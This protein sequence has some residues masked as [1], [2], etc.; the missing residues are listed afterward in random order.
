MKD[1]DPTYQAV[2]KAVR[3]RWRRRLLAMAHVFAFF[4]AYLM[5]WERTAWYTGSVQTIWFIVLGFHLLWAV[6]AEL[7]DDAIRREI[8][9]ERKW[10]LLEQLEEADPYARE[11]ILR[12][13]D[14][15]DG[16]LIDFDA[17][18]WAEN[19]KRKRG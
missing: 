14:A 12:L 15:P 13:A 7:R 1:T 4:A 8:E 6:I 5:I 11:R 9:R 16:E 10:R 17:E 18:A 2:A 3:G 19:V